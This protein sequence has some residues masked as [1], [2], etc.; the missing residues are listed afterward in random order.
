VFGQAHWFKPPAVGDHYYPAGFSS[1]VFVFGSSYV[2]PRSANVAVRLTGLMRGGNLSEHVME[3]IA[4]G[5]DNRPVTVARANSEFVLTLASNS[6][7]LG[8]NFLHPITRRAT[9]FKGVVLQKQDWASGYFPGTNQSGMVFLR[10][11]ADS[12][13]TRWQ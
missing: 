5:V 7:L 2:P 1:R 13:A 11:Q 10:A 8:G 6:G 4:L 12:S 9:P 3:D